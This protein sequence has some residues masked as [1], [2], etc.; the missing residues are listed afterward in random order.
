MIQLSCIGRAKP[1]D[2]GGDPAGARG[3][4][5]GR[6]PRPFAAGGG[7]GL[8]PVPPELPRA[9]DGP[10]VRP[11]P[12]ATRRATA[13]S[14]RSRS[15][16]GAPRTS[17]TTSWSSEIVDRLSKAL[18]HDPGRPRVH[19]PR[20]LGAAEQE[21]H[22]VVQPQLLAPSRGLGRDVPEG[23]RRRRCPG[24]VSDGTNPAFWGDQIDAFMRTPR[25]AR[26]VVRAA[27]RDPRAR[28]RRRRR[29]AGQGVARRVR[30]RLRGAGTRLPGA[31]PLPDGGL[32]AAR[33]RD[34]ARERVAAYGDQV[35]CA[36]ARLPQP[37]PRAVAPARQGALRAHLQPLRQPP[38]RRADARRRPRVRAARPGEHHAAARSGELAERYGVRE[39]RSGVHGP[40]RAA[41]RPRG[42]RATSSA[43]CASGR[44]SGTRCTSRRSTRRSRRRRR[45]A[46]PRAP[47]C[48][49]TSCWTS[50][51]SGPACTRRP[52]RWRASRRRSRCCTTRAC[53]SRRTCSCARR[54][55][56]RP[57]AAR[58]SSRARSSTGSTARCSSSSASARGFRVDVEPFAYRERSNTVVLVAR[59]R[60]AYRALGAT[61]E[62]ATALAA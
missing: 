45:C 56:T 21:R 32:L 57:T 13:R 43:A 30:G 14:R 9:G 26:R 22:L 41:A 18:G 44:T 17:R 27:R 23:L 24:G 40:G 6:R 4:R 46:S 28:V 59:H 34:R 20:G 53:S 61:A 42:V 8:G 16:S 51:R 38:D 60:D 7:P 55:S 58:A 62:L 50:C 33:A 47:T 31:R 29:P 49:S 48:T 1:E 35:E 10:P 2:L 12:G 36:R 25:P 5:R 11:R 15:T 52:W 3:G 37:D 54:A 39:A 19:P